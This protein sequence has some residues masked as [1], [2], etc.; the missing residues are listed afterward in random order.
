GADHNVEALDL[1]YYGGMIAG[2]VPEAYRQHITDMQTSF[3]ILEGNN[4]S[5]N[6]MTENGNGLD[7]HRVKAIFY[8]LFFGA[9]NPTEVGIAQFADCFVTYEQRTNTWMDDDGV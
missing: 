3:A 5:I 9:E 4:A 2:E 1:S 6:A 7:S 8:S